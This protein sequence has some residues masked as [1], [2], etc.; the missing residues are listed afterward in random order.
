MVGRFWRKSNAD[1]KRISVVV[2]TSSRA[3]KDILASYNLNTN[4]YIIKP[5]DID[6]FFETIRSTEHFWLTS[7][8]RTPR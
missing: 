4:C 7:V 1:L 8:T 5:A 6:Q 3:D 2:L